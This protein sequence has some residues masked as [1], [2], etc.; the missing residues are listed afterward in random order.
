MKVHILCMRACAVYDFACIFGYVCEC[1]L[2]V[3]SICLH[4]VRLSKGHLFPV[5][6]RPST[7]AACTKATWLGS[8]AEPVTLT[9]SYDYCFKVIQKH[10]I[11]VH[12]HGICIQQQQ[13]NLQCMLCPIG[14]ETVAFDYNSECLADM[15]SM[16]LFSLLNGLFALLSCLYSSVPY[17][18]QPPAKYLLP[19]VSINDYGKN[20]VVIDLDETLVHSSFK[21]LVHTRT[22]TQILQLCHYDISYSSEYMVDWCNWLLIGFALGTIDF[23]YIGWLAFEEFKVTFAVLQKLVSWLHREPFSKKLSS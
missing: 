4:Q 17:F 15:I 3:K 12:H 2:P 19:E 21:V 1:V 16:H 18:L 23:L 10:Q 9:Q 14:G 5:T 22:Q 13:S 11:P 7:E 8:E 6:G 20:C